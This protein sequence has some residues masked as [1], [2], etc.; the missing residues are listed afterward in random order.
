[1]IVLLLIA[2]V[3]FCVVVWRENDM[4][5]LTVVVESSTRTGDTSSYSWHHIRVHTHAHLQVLNVGQDT[6]HVGDEW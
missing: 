1:M 3:V 6:E 5:F 4:Y 2:V